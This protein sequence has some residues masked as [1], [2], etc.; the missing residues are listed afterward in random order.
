MVVA[1]DD[2]GEGEEEE[3]S[4]SGLVHLAEQ[5]APHTRDKK[6]VEQIIRTRQFSYL[7][8][9]CIS[10]FLFFFFLLRSN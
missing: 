8:V 2:E 9:S 1:T 10:F 3:H 5:L 4:W 7:A 6:H